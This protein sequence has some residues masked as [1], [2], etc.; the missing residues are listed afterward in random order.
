LLLGAAYD[1]TRGGQIDGH[2]AAQYHQGALGIDY[3]LS[4]RTDLYAVAVY[5][6][7]LGE[8]LSTSGTAI[9]PAVASISGLTASTNRN[10]LAVR[11]GIR[12][13]F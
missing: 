11:A 3:F 6:R 13:K 4:K 8:T 10:Q 12:S 7:A 9:V 1:Y 5:Q 2:S